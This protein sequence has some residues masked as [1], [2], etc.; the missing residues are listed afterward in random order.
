MLKEVYNYTVKDVCKYDEGRTT[1]RSQHV[2]T[3]L[4][5]CEI[6]ESG[7]TG[8]P[9]TFEY[10]ILHICISREELE[11]I[12]VQ[13]FKYFGRLLLGPRRSHKKK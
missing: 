13:V 9:K 6:G 3:F 4:T 10:L 11:K 8:E 1:C 5:F 7:R 2:C 12:N